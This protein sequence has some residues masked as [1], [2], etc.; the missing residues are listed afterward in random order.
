MMLD[1]QHK[2]EFYE[3]CFNSMP[4]GILVFDKTQK[5]IL[6]NKVLA[7]IFGYNS[8]ELHNKNAEILLKDKYL[9]ENYIQNSHN[10]N[11]KNNLECVGISKNGNEVPVEMSFGKIEYDNII[12]YKALIS[13][14]SI[15]KE[16]ELRINNLNFE[17]EKEVALRNK[18]L[19]KV[20]EQLK[21]TID[22]E[23]ELNQ[24]K[25]RFISLASHE[26]K[27]PLSA[28]LTSTELIVKYADLDNKIKREEHL[29]KVKTM[30]NYL[31]G[32]LDD[33]LTLENI[34]A[35]NIKPNFSQFKFNKVVKDIIKQIKPFLKVK[36]TL[37]FENNIDETIYQDPKILK[38]LLT[39]LLYNAIKYSDEDGKINVKISTDKNNI[40]LNI[41]DNGIG[42]PENE[43]NLIFNRFFRA[44]NAVYY[45]GTGIGLNIVKG[46][47]T[48]L[49]GSISFKSTE[50]K[51][52]VFKV[53]LPKI[54]CNEQ[55]SISN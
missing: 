49:K 55:K 22:K 15:R 40:Y 1:D 38:I 11:F 23:K 41:K 53:Q 20:I 25:T 6:F 33:F 4:I 10:I 50:N 18:E 43:Q 31:N 9:L 32:M 29:T 36:Q 24:L 16:K 28:I 45:P 5:I 39:N 48:S 42:I 7:E 13:D 54:N 12:Y 35:G 34:E 37:N 3:V 2:K 30:I 8:D 27:T 52:T 14:I 21:K 17:L 51:G 44:K 47:I 46:Y 26:F 19:E